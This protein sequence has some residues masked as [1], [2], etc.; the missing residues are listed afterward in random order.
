MSCRP[1]TEP[2][3]LQ[4]FREDH[5]GETNTLGVWKAQVAVW[6]G[7]AGGLED[8]SDSVGQRRTPRIVMRMIQVRL[9]FGITR[10]R[11][12]PPSM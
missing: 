12:P 6:K 11:S 8:C 9:P 3:I 10:N 2:H 4:S 1:L 5:V 7:G